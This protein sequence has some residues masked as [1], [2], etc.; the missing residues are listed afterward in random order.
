MSCAPEPQWRLLTSGTLSTGTG[1]FCVF[2]CTCGDQRLTSGVLIHHPPPYFYKTRSL[3]EL[4]DLARLACQQTPGVLLALP[5]LRWDYGHV[6]P[7]LAFNVGAGNSNSDPCA[8]A[9]SIL[10]T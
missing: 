5:P 3:M 4:P 7:H 6:P 10:P 1:I 2:V 9:A 8:C